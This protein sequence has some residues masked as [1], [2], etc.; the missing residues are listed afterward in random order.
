MKSLFRNLTILGTALSACSLA[1]FASA[2]ITLTTMGSAYT[3]NF[4]TLSNTAGSISNSLT[5]NGWFMTESGGGT[6]DNELYAVDTGSSNT[7]DTYSYG[8]AGSTERAL[9]ALRSG[10]LIPLFG[11][12]FTNVTGSTIASLAIAYAGEEWRLGTA[13][14]TDAINFEYSTNATNLTT[15]TWIGVTALDF[16][17]P[18]TVTTGAKNGNAAADRTVISST[19]AGL[20]IANG[21]SFWIRWSDKDA[22]GAD[23]GLA[24]DDF[25]LTPNRAATSGVVPEASMFVT[26]G[27]LFGL[28]GLT[29]LIRRR[30]SD[31]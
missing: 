17:T 30:G 21:A 16:T 15:G 31:R 27:G 3:Q 12:N 29:R 5:I 22:T 10:T 6:R 18:D 1:S 2:A 8:A 19:I 25:S 4:D 20:S 11:A 14:R 24:V 7:G 13:G 9:G 23:D 26:M 28:G